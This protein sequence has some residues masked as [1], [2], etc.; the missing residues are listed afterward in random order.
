MKIFSIVLSILLFLA[1]TSYAAQKA[2]TDTGEEIIINSDG[3]WEYADKGQNVTDKIQT[4]KKEFKRS[5]DASFQLK[6][7]KNDSAYWINTDKWSFKKPKEEGPTEYSFQL[8]GKDVYGMAIT[9]AI[10][11]NLDSLTNIALENARKVAPDVKIISQEYRIVNGN[12]VV[13]MQMNGT[14][15]GA[16][17][18]YIGYYHSN[19]SGSTQLVN[20]SSP[21]IIDKYKSDILEFLN[22]FDLQ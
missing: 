6:S 10:E 19:A 18:T 3:T 11:I 1:A 7:T 15:K 17:F 5:E 21:N 2:I 4:N 13:F 9:E 20:Y 16:N 12:K 8:K 14:I 22:G